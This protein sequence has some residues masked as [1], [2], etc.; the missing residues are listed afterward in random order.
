MDVDEVHTDAVQSMNPVEGP[1]AGALHSRH[2]AFS[3]PLSATP[4]SAQ[5]DS[6]RGHG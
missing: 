2:W 4:L 6:Q 3:F 5:P 1:V